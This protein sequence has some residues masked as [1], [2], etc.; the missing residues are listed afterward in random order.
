MLVFHVHLHPLGA[1][2]RIADG[3]HAPVELAGNVLDQRFLS[4]H[5][6]V[7]EHAI[8]KAELGGELVQD[9]VIG[10]RFKQRLD[11]L[12]PPLQR[13]VRRGDRPRGFELRRRGQQIGVVGAVVQH[14]G[15]GRVRIDHDQ[16]VEL[17]HRRLHFLLTGL[18]VGRMTPQHHRFGVVRLFQVFAC[19]KN[20][21]DPARNGNAR[22]PHHL[23]VLAIGALDG[24]KTALEPIQVFFPDARPVG[25]RSGRQTVIARQRIG[26]NAQIGRPLHVVVATE[27]VGATTGG[28]HVP[29][30]KLKDAIGAGIVVA[31]GVLRATHAP[32]HGAG[33]VVGQRAG[34]A[35]QLCLGHTCHTFNL[36]RCP[37]GHLFADL[38][39]APDTGANEFLILPTVVKDM[40][41]N[42][43]HQ[44]HVRTGPEAHEFVRMGRRA[45]KA[46]V[47]DDQRR[48]VLFL[49]FQQ[50]LKRHGVRLGGVAADDEDRL[51]VVDVVI[52]V[53]HGA[54]APCVRNTRN[55]RRVADTRLVIDVVGAPIG[56][57]L[58]EQVCLFVRMLGAAQPVDAVGT[59]CVTDRRHLVAD[60]VDRLLPADPLPFAAD[61]LHRVL[62]AAFAVGVFTHRCALGA[63]G[64]QVE[65]AVP[66]G[67]LPD[68]DTARHFGDDC[69]THRTV[70]ADG[71]LDLDGACRRCRCGIGLLDGAACRGNGSKAANGQP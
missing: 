43:P 60:L 4:V 58:A 53:G 42:T 49:G 11:N 10:Q 8:R 22:Q 71:F 25:P 47:A 37:V 63:V 40:V 27:N 41:Q 56:R 24:A 70:G 2:T 31:V 23:L 1:L 16:Q 21:V 13:S 48:V 50:V 17:F 54:V 14:G 67:F 64:A 55:G 20:T 68:P 9:R 29:Q 44:R 26:Q 32:D 36:V 18:R 30:R 38:V 59:G 34:H 3:P 69:A 7:A 35:F 65:R 28:A 19:L 51:G 39:H 33:A 15:N 46:R 62:Q 57:E 12:F 66:A 5:L 61:F 45:G 52:A 6:D